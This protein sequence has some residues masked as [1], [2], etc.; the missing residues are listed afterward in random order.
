[1]KNLYHFNKIFILFFT[2]IVISCKVDIPSPEAEKIFGT[3]RLI[4]LNVY[5]PPYNTWQEVEFKRKGIFFK[6]NNGKVVEKRR[7]RISN[8]KSTIFQTA[9]YQIDYNIE[10]FN[11]Y[12][13]ETQVIF[14]YGNDTLLLQDDGYDAAS[15][16]YVRK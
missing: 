3:W 2:I 15:Y 13:T 1:M 16:W 4:K 7:F 6:Y 5:Y 9:K 14:F 8:N 10:I 12:P 11:N